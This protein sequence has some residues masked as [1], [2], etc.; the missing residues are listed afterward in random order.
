MIN[1][2]NKNDRITNEE[3]TIQLGTIIGHLIDHKKLILSSMVMFALIGGLYSW[4]ATPIYKADALIQVEQNTGNSILTNLSSILP[5][6]QPASAPEIELLKSRMVLG[7]AVEE[8]NLD[9]EVKPKN[10]PIIGRLY[11]KFTGNQQSNLPVISFNV[12]SE[13][14][15]VEY[16]VKAVSNNEYELFLDGNKIFSGKVGERKE[17]NGVALYIADTTLTQ[18]NTY[19]LKKIAEVT[20]ISN[21]LEQLNISEKGKD[22]GIISL[23]INGSDPVK[24]KN[25]LSVISRIYLSQNIERKSAEAA[26]SLDF[27]DKQLPEIRTALDESENKLNLYRQQKDSVDLSLEAKSVLDTVVQLDSQLNELTFREAEIS[28]LYTKEH[29]SYKALLEKRRTLEDEKKRLSGKITALPQTQQEILKLTRD[30]QVN[31]EIYMQLLNKKQELSISKAS[32]VGNI[33]IIDPAITN[34]EP[35]APQSVLII[36]MM[37]IFGAIVSIVYIIIHTILHKGIQSAEQLEEMGMNVYASVPLSELQFDKTNKGGK[38]KAKRGI[39]SED[40]PADVTV[41]AIRSLRTSL[42]F[43]TMEAR[44]N[45]IMISGP[46]PGI[47]KSFISTN[48]AVVIAQANMRVLLIDADLRR[49]ELH[50]DFSIEMK[51]GLSDLLSNSVEYEKAII[52]NKIA[53]LD[54]L[55]RGQVPPNPSELLMRKQFSNLLDW[56]SNNYDLVIIDTPPVFAV[57]DPVIIGKHAGT[58]FLVALFE[59]NTVKEIDAAKRRFENNG[60]NING[61]ILNGVVKRATNKYGNYAY[62]QYSY[63]SDKR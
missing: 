27:L 60:I 62:Y 2:L 44:N 20:A 58:S 41:E 11:N 47:G 16:I 50:K 36:L 19:T 1:D 42:H 30:V 43:A 26:K 29:P 38:L 18:G 52:K 54:F 25:I 15:N 48:L 32:T 7:G 59:G 35:I 5:D 24:I 22:T 57:T 4:I 37:T 61:I 55:P 14:Y 40:S 13:N 6:N 46:N 21:L 10:F 49:G 28:K 17:V 23:S 63:D 45:I 12:P 9:I 56:A 53:N 39:L 33:R 34:P 31:Q 3:D 8:L 51:N